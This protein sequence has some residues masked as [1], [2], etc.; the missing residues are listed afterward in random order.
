MSNRRLWIAITLVV[1]AG[2]TLG[3][4][5]RTS[6]RPPEQDMGARR[7]RALATAKQF[8][9]TAGLPLPQSDPTFKLLDESWRRRN[10]CELSWVG[11]YRLELTP[12]GDSVV[13]FHNYARE[14][15][16]VRGL[17][18]TGSS[19]FHSSREAAEFL[20]RMAKALGLPPSGT[21]SELKLAGDNAPG[22]GDANRAGIATATFV[23]HPSD[24]P[25]LH[26][27]NGMTVS[28]DPQDGVLTYFAASWDNVIM[29]SKP[30]ATPSLAR[31]EAEKLATPLYLK[32]R[33]PLFRSADAPTN[34]KLGWVVPNPSY[35]SGHPPL[36]SSARPYR[37]RLAWVVY[38]GPDAVFIDP[39]DGSVLG[40]LETKGATKARVGGVD[41]RTGPARRWE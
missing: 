35:G 15:A 29:P 38:F 9:A 14:A 2:T 18:R 17:D 3:L 6:S 16:Q 41:G 24:Y 27:G 39:Y 31:T 30:A 40:G 1:A 11:T 26:C 32:H 10:G 7:E 4:S 23:I 28:V 36:S 25:F 34:A 20:T 19:I 37:V 22:H 5:R 13:S 33:R 12:D 21:L 8:L